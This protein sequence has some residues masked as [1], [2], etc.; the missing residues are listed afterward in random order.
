MGKPLSCTNKLSVTIT[1]PT[2]LQ[3]NLSA[4]H[5]IFYLVA[6]CHLASYQY[7][8]WHGINNFFLKKFNSLKLF[9]FDFA[10]MLVNFMFY[11]LKT[12]KQ[13]KAAMDV[14]IIQKIE[15][16]G[17]WLLGGA[18]IFPFVLV[19]LLPI[20]YVFFLFYYPIYFLPL[21]SLLPPFPG[22]CGLL[23]SCLKTTFAG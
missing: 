1:P 12:Q 20:L 2:T 13:T 21:I 10:F 9:S 19:P 6:Y 8:C 3:I 11:F 16:E 17:C 23:K 4:F 22:R 18:S 7:A 14:H 15:I 5:H